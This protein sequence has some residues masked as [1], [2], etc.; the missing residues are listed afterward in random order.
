VVLQL[1]PGTVL[2]TQKISHTQGGRGPRLDDEDQLGRAVANLGDLDG[3]GIP[4]LAAAGHTDDDG[5]L[6]Q[7][8][9]YV[10]FLRSD[11]L[12]R[13]TQ[14]ISALE[15]GF[16]GDLDAGDQFGRSLAGIGDLD[17]DGVR[18]LAV[19]VNYDDDGG[20]NRGAVYLLTLNREG[21]VKRTSKISS[22]SGGFTGI[23]R[24]QDEFGRSVT[25]PGDLD[26]DGVPELAV[27]APTDNTGGTR[28]GAVWILFLRADGTVKR[29]VKVAQNS[30]GFIGHLRNFDW[31]GFSVA[32][33]GDFDRDGVPDL[34]VGSALDDDGAV[35]AGAVWL[36][37]LNADGTV[38]ATRKISMLSG[39]FNALLEYPDQF[40]TSV[41]ALGDVNG[42][43]V[44]DLAVGAVKD[45]DGG[46]ENGAVYVLFLT[47][48]G[49]VAAHQKIS[50]LEG[51]LGLRLDNWDWFGSSL[52]ALG[53]FSRDG[54][55]DF[56]VGA[57]NDDDGGPNRGALYITRL[58]GASAAS[59]APLAATNM[60]FAGAPDS[61]ALRG[62]SAAQ[63]RFAEPEGSL[64]C[65]AG[66]A[67]PG[68]AV[69]LDLRVPESLGTGGASAFL[70]VAH[71]RG[72]VAVAEATGAQL[73]PHAILARFELALGP[74][75]VQREFELKL[76]ALAA[77]SGRELGAQV[78]WR[79]AEAQAWSDA[80]VLSVE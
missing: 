11:G 67:R 36:L 66:Q 21:T 50:E 2:G 76:P 27:G 20:M 14:K 15:G 61:G 73:D 9:A 10:L 25:S 74:G 13:A 43:G 6:D 79:T 44:T 17:G 38:K 18:D 69:R 19:G 28:R 41:A 48:D 8:A 42:D 16:T 52:V 68:G 32:P 22:L 23:L 47:P 4:E 12:V 63:G 58:R 24:N 65:S 55:P 54:V 35:N 77:L 31:F 1:G 5:G 57:R 59:V 75:E 49:K 3:D 34:V 51:S 26:G 7:G 30:G 45:G 70:F 72:P 33:L 29:W 62:T 53:D 71:R 80:L 78:L 40:G 56:A 37:F 39:N 64:T 46:K 60:P